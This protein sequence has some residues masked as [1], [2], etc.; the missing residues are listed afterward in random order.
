MKRK[1]HKIFKSHKN[2]RKRTILLTGEI[3]ALNKLQNNQKMNFKGLAILMDLGSKM[4]RSLKRSLKRKMKRKC[5]IFLICE[6]LCWK[7]I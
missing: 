1:S 6:N 4:K 3:S 7:N 5:L 2:K